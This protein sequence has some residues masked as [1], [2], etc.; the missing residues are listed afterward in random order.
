MLRAVIF[1]FDGII[2]D[3]EPLILKLTQEM[4]AK[5]GWILTEDE[6]YRDYLAIDD[7]GIMNCLYR[8]HQRPVNEVRRE[9]LIA[10]KVCAYEQA[11]RNGL[12]PV[13]GVIEF[14]NQLAARFPLAIASGSR[15]KEI[16]HLLGMLGLRER[17]AV[18][19]SADDCA[20][21]KPH[22]EVFLKALGR[23]QQLP[24]FRKHALRADEVLAI[25]DAPVGVVAAHAAGVKCLALSNN[26]SRADLAHADW[27]HRRFAEIDLAAI[28]AAFRQQ[29]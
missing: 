23:L 19:V 26:R 6:Y 5:E 11:I 3:S 18:L 9:E 22:P 10:E 2:V 28:E 12:P 15:Q 25:E 27:V 14:V 17:F 29:A 20:Q 24:A 4:A 1:D 13:P 16:G 21:S 8:I 7:R